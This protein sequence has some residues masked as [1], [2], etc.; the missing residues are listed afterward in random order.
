VDLLARL[1]R[2]R[3]GNAVMRSATP[4]V[5]GSRRLSWFTDV[6]LRR[7]WLVPA[8]VCYAILTVLAARQARS[9]SAPAWGRDE[10]SRQVTELG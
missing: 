5:R 3:R 9:S 10:S 7:P 2:V 8:G 4:G 1:A 6:V